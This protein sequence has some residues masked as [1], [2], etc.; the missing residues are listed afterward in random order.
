MKRKAST[1]NLQ[2]HRISGHV[3]PRTVQANEINM[4][5]LTWWQ[6]SSRVW[7]QLVKHPRTSS[8]PDP[9]S[10]VQ[11]FSHRVRVEKVSS[12][13]SIPSPTSPWMCVRSVVSEASIDDFRVVSPLI[14]VSVWLAW[15]YYYAVSSSG[16]LGHFLGCCCHREIS[17]VQLVQFDNT[18]KGAVNGAVSSHLFNTNYACKKIAES[19]N[20]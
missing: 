5:G 1:G 3:G 9:K 8:A 10:Y 13:R 19:E 11:L 6:K 16:Q 2:I 12:L 7:C 17:L 4:L 15:E 20:R 18:R 14:G